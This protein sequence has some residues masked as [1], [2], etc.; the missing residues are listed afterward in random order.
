MGPVLLALI[1]ASILLPAAPRA[2]A[3]GDVDGDGSPEIVLLLAWPRWGSA[4][5]NGATAPGMMEVDVVPAVEERR[6]IRVLRLADGRL[7]P[8]AT[9]L[10][11]GQEVLAL[12]AGG[13]RQ[14]VLVLADGG[15]FR[16][17]PVPSAAAGEPP[18]LRLEQVASIPGHLLSGTGRV[19]SRF[20]FVRDLDG[21]P[22]AE[23]TVPVQ[24]G[25]LL[26]QPGGVRSRLPAPVARVEGTAADLA[27]PVPADLD[28]DG[29][30]DLV[31]WLDRAAGPDGHASLGR[32]ALF[33]GRGRLAW[34]PPR[35]F[36]LDPLLEVLLPPAPERDPGSWQGLVVA[37][38]ADWDRD[39][40]PEVALERRTLAV[41]SAREALRTFRRAPVRYTF[42]R[43]LPGG[44]VEERPEWTLEA[45]GLDYPFVEGGPRSPFA[46]LDGDGVPELVT[47]DL[48]IGWFGVGRAL[49][50]GT[51]RAFVR[52]HLFRFAGGR[53]REVAG[54]V[55]QL[56]G[57]MNLREGELRRFARWP[58]DL[59]GDG[60]RE[61]VEVAE[62]QLRIR[63]GRP[64]PRWP[65]RPDARVRLA[66]PLRHW[67]GM[68]AVDLDGVPPRELLLV[69][70]V[71]VRG[72]RTPE[73]EELA[74]PVLLEI[75]RPPLPGETR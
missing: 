24:D 66:G 44:R 52:P 30:G 13:P 1:A 45:T 36:D 28:G 4:L 63:Y 6:E 55:P 19:V 49:V 32:V 10:R 75:V 51:G 61:L 33:R 18:R 7:A 54:A 5:R 73:G 42:H 3:V 21:R 57:R 27:I 2:I 58:A 15:I 29:T 62:D 8:A 12:G 53:F 20:P 31:A 14:P 47:V 23:V 11:V 48:G 40:T 67:L 34:A 69:E 26:V 35:V 60:I 56:V 22:P 38:V 16:L 50:T 37:G 41:S 25:F 65:A 17:A 59:D 46:D 9:P 43:L 68:Q 64:G 39:G 70:T 71:P 74:E 72:K